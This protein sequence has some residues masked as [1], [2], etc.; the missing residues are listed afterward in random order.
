M[1]TKKI[2]DEIKKPDIVMRTAEVALEFVRAHLRLVIIAAVVFCAAGLSVYGYTV[3]Q[4]KQNEKVQTAITEGVK[5]L[6]SYYAS[7]KKEDLDKAETTFQKVVKERKGK[8]YLVAKLYLGTV[9]ALK[10]QND[11]ARNV[12]QELS[13]KSPTVLRMLAEKDLQKLDAKK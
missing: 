11:D 9:Y 7:G 10:G 4:D 12:Y 6:E 3:Y 8:V 13:R 2:K 1:A 5:N